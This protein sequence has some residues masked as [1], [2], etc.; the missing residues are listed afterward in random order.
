MIIILGVIVGIVFLIYDQSRPV[1]PVQTAT[2]VQQPT[3]VEPPAILN[4][5][6]TSTPVFSGELAV[7]PS[8]TPIN[9]SDLE[10]D[11]VDA[12]LF[13]PR[14]GITAPIVRVYVGDA[15]WDVSKL[16]DNV[17][18]LQGTRW[19]P[20]AGNVVLSGHVELVDGRQGVFANL[21]AL[22]IGDRIT[23]SYDDIDYH[24]DVTT[25]ENHEPTDLT[26]VYPTSD[27]RLT[28]I[29]CGNY[30]FFTDTYLERVVVVAEQVAVN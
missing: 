22:Q 3:Q 29:T 19:L 28:L 30:D 16:G 17:G 10:P 9:A 14:A 25:I 1:V 26:P 13:I 20:E 15:S 6:A 5:D 12:S 11:I 21:N 23:I 18:H 24:Y 8:P 27:N 7:T 2:P 4:S